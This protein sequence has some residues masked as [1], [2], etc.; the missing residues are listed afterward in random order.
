MYLH[1]TK[2][3][4]CIYFPG[5]DNYPNIFTSPSGDPGVCKKYTGD[6][7]IDKKNKWDNEDRRYLVLFGKIRCSAAQPARTALIDCAYL[8]VLNNM[9]ETPSSIAWGMQC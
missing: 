7:S 5:N 1:N 6:S 9:H 3:S 2:L 8:A 4:Q